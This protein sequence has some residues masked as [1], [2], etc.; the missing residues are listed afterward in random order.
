MDETTVVTA[1]MAP[2]SGKA[3]FS[4]L[5]VMGRMTDTKIV[6]KEICG[7]WI[8]ITYDLPNTEE[9]NKMRYKFYGEAQRIGATQQTESV[10]FM[11]WT[12]EA[13]M[14]ALELSMAGKC[15]IWTADV[16]NEDHAKDLTDRYDAGLRPILK[17]IETRVD[18][19]IF[20]I[21]NNHP[22]IAKGMV[23]KTDE[24]I[25]NLENAIVRRGSAM[26]L[27]ALSSVK[28]CFNIAVTR[29]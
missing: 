4:T 13:E 22:G 26:M 1:E 19:I 25:T 10:Y 9:G 23:D 21:D 16:R 29:I 27:I 8:L 2:E 28:K 3:D 20:H 14:L 11:P 6:A 24:M 17:E 7:K 18:K 12:P 15:I 5:E